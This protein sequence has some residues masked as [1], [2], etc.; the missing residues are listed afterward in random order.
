MIKNKNNFFKEM[1]KYFLL[2]LLL[3]QSFFSQNT[4]GVFND[5]FI[6]TN[7]IQGNPSSFLQSSNPWELNIISTD[8]FLNNAELAPTKCLEVHTEYVEE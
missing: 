7:A 4:T 2:I 8:V 1:K 5:G 3:Y 6:F